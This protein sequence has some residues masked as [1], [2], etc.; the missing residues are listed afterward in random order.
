MRK[1]LRQS[2]IILEKM[3][4][5]SLF[6]WKKQERRKYGE[7]DRVKKKERNN[8][9]ECECFTDAAV[10]IIHRLKLKDYKV[11]SALFDCESSE[12]VNA[13][14]ATPGHLALLTDTGV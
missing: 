11:N 1:K 8:R 12:C 13:A 14:R 3:Y 6:L 2:R 4:I 10:F 7:D 9:R 5:C